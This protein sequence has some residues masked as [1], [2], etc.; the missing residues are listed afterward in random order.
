M[1]LSKRISTALSHEA[2]M[3]PTSTTATDLMIMPGTG[4]VICG[5][6]TEDTSP[7]AGRALVLQNFNSI[8][9]GSLHGMQVHGMRVHTG[10]GEE[11]EEEG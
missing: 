4:H 11:T 2:E 6:G 10:M 1:Q 5:G 9:L 7:S 3:C 8:E